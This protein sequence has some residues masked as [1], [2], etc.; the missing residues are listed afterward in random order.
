[1]EV[2]SPHINEILDDDISDLIE[3]DNWPIVPVSRPITDYNNNFNENEFLR[4]QELLSATN[5]MQRNY[6]PVATEE[7]K[8]FSDFLNCL[9]RKCENDIP[10]IVKM[11]QSLR[12]FNTICESDQI[13]LLKLGTREAILFRSVVT[14]DRNTNCCIVVE[15]IMVTIL[16]ALSSLHQ[17][18][19]CLLN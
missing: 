13:S 15:V 17:F 2:L 6:I 19:K 3:F 16:I 4:L 7:P 12:G 1:M 10:V 14:I 8:Q 9:H 5:H 11:C 18:I